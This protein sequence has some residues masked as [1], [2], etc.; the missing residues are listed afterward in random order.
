MSSSDEENQEDP[1]SEEDIVEQAKQLLELTNLVEKYPSVIVRRVTGLT[2]V[3]VGG[4]IAFTVL[5]FMSI[6]EFIGFVGDTVFLVAVFVGISLLIAW[7]IPFRL[8]L[9]LTKTYPTPEGAPEGMSNFLK[10]AW[11]VVGSMMIVFSMVTFGIG[12]PNLFPV[13]VQLLMTAGNVA[14]FYEGRRGPQTQAFAREHLVFAVFVAFSVI[15]MLL[16]PIIAYPILI[17]VDV[18][19]IYM[20]GVY[21]II[22]AEKLLLES[23]R[24][25]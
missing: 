21:M 5:L 20:L 22:T 10:A 23:S 18:G 16:L 14:N 15:P 13:A 4:G 12:L 6:M 24:R 9:P 1:T 3:L 19:G 25:S 7:G 2:Y 17:L 11:A 8:I